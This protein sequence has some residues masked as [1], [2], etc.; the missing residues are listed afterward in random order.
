MTC[1]A[2]PLPSPAST[3]ARGGTDGCSTAAVS[4]AGW[5]GPAPS[6]DDRCRLVP[7]GRACEVGRC[8]LGEI[9][10]RSCAAAQ[11][12]RLLYVRRGVSGGR[13]RGRARHAGGALHLQ[14]Q[15]STCMVLRRGCPW[16]CLAVRCAQRPA[17]P[18]RA[19]ERAP[20]MIM[21]ACAWRAPKRGRARWDAVAQRGC[22]GAARGRTRAGACRTAW[23][24]EGSGLSGYGG[25][26][27]RAS[28]KIYSYS[29]L[30]ASL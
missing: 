6:R 24:I 13:A 1:G 29:S 2:S 22:G 9:S 17:T 11:C 4:R 3:H 18:A 26:S 20:S 30:L 27:P 28:T 23:L 5:L 10:G 15:S 14:R 7:P 16:S 25:R 8:A 19:R 21:R 12:A